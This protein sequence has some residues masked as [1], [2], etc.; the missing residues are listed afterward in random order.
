[1][2]FNSSLLIFWLRNHVS[3]IYTTEDEAPVQTSLLKSV[4]LNFELNF[5]RHSGHTH[6]KVKI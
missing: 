6:N 4:I 5:M 1:M 2:L 3:T